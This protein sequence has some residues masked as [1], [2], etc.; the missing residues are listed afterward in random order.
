MGSVV[1]A[2]GVVL[3][4][5]GATLL[6]NVGGLSIRLASY[7][8]KRF[9]HL[10]TPGPVGTT[11]IGWRIIGVACAG[12]GLISIGVATSGSQLG[13]YVA[14]SGVLLFVGGVCGGIIITA[15]PGLWGR[16]R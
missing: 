2:L 11:S 13:G 8:R 3:V 4:V 1:A 10:P 16:S 6:V 5:A 14:T 7:H 12:F 9:G 15:I